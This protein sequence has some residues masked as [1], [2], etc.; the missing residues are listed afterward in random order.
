[1]T[2]EV[3]EIVT[4]LLRRIAA[5]HEPA[6][7]DL[8]RHTLAWLGS[9]IRRIVRDP[10]L[11]EEVLQDV[12]LYIWLHAA[13]YRGD[14]GRPSA[15]LSMLARSRALDR[16]RV[17]RREPQ[18]AEHIE[19]RCAAIAT[20]CVDIWRNRR[21]RIALLEL[22]A[23]QRHLITLGYFDGLSHAEIAE[24]ADLPLGT[25]K[26]RIRTALITLR[27]K[28]RSEDRPRRAA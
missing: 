19:A 20:D 16:L 18:A 23:N 8:R 28:V 17:V 15:W 3:Q 1:M 5:G 26:S 27:D 2:S 9:Q 4:N 22:P 25:V 21:L 14:R 13:D 10:W 12:Y 24:R 6:L 11:A 7:C